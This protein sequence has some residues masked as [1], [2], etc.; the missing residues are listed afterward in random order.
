MVGAA[1]TRRALLF[2]ASITPQQIQ[3]HL[4][5][6]ESAT[7]GHPLRS[8]VRPAAAQRALRRSSSFCI[9]CI[10]FSRSSHFSTSKWGSNGTVRTLPNI[11]LVSPTTTETDA[12]LPRAVEEVLAPLPPN[13]HLTLAM[14]DFAYLI[15]EVCGAYGYRGLEVSRF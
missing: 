8:V 9:Y 5:A 15:V 4:L 10:V 2:P 6:Q 14:R 1:A 12:S 11:S 3:K 7:E 13:H